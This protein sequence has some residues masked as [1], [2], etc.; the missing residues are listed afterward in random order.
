MQHESGSFRDRSNRVVYHNGEVYRML[1]SDA[2]ASWRD[3]SAT[4]FFERALKRGDIVA[5]AE[6]DQLAAE[7]SARKWAGALKHERIPFVSYPYEWCFGM[8]K[9]AALLH[10]DLLLE[11]LEEGLMIKDSSAYNIQWRGT[12][13][14][15]IDT[16]SFEK[17]NSGEPWIAYRQF[18]EMFLFPLMLASYKGVP[19]NTY[20]RGDIDG[21]PVEVCSRLLSFRDYFRRGCFSHVYLQSKLQKRYS[22]SNRDVK[23]E[24]SS[25]G[26][27]AELIKINVRKLK[28]LVSGL[29]IGISK[30]TWS[31]YEAVSIS[32]DT[33]TE[34]NQQQKADFVR[35]AVLSKPQS[36]V[37]DLGCNTGVYSRIAAESAEQVVAMDFDPLAVEKLY[38]TLKQASSGNVLPLVVNIANASPAQGWRGGERKRLEDRGKPSLVLG[39][40]LMH[41]LVLSANVP[42][43]Q[44]MGWLASLQA[45]LVLEF[46]TRHDP[47]VKKLLLNKTDNYSDYTIENFEELIQQHHQIKSRVELNNRQRVLYHCIAR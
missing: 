26:F 42:L 13:P 33:Y 3:I 46:V 7:S 36:M 32:N 44:L 2:L 24:L 10:L 8:L 21:I 17:W 38:Q 41:H 25:A 37:W 47:M 16:P 22:D 27:H 15:F 5:T 18:C 29:T 23:S 30:T 28:K 9:D 12:K 11:A 34:G 14:V 20:L 4:E 40:A 31:D 45:D 35:S 1:D 6:T 43:D 19:F 39:L